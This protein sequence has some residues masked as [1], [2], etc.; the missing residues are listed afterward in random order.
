MLPS[1]AWSTAWLVGMNTV[2]GP[3]PRS[4]GGDP[5]FCKHIHLIRTEDLALIPILNWFQLVW[6]LTGYYP[7]CIFSL[8]IY[9]CIKLHCWYEMHHQLNHWDPDTAPG[10]DYWY[11]SGTGGLT[12]T[13]AQSVHIYIYIWGEKSNICVM[14]LAKILTSTRDRK[15]LYLPS[16]VRISPIVL[17]ANWSTE[18]DN[19]I[20]DSLSQ[21]VKSAELRI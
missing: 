8:Y 18:D 1:L 15:R 20:A 3:G 4:G 10:C 11:W 21:T 6:Q 5:Q 19:Q 9:M 13:L 12:R 14:L 17:S 7:R 16:L 2:R